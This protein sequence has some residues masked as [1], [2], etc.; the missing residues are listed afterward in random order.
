MR[1]D[2]GRKRTDR[3]PEMRD[4]KLAPKRGTCIQSPTIPEPQLA[5][6]VTQLASSIT[7]A[8]STSMVYL[9]ALPALFLFV[10]HHEAS[11][12]HSITQLREPEREGVSAIRTRAF[13]FQTRCTLHSV[14][15]SSATLGWSKEKLVA[16]WALTVINSLHNPDLTEKSRRDRSQGNMDGMKIQTQ[17]YSVLQCIL[18]QQ[19]LQ[20]YST[21][22]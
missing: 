6:D 19:R 12:R 13:F 5:I 1:L 16:H 18:C 8:E 2:R 17:R 14:D 9:E 7:S 11:L 15:R 22:K 3:C 20:P 10:V 21:A 4:N